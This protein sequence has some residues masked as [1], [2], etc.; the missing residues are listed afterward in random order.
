MNTIIA[1]TFIGILTYAF[2]EEPSDKTECKHEPMANF[3]PTKYLQITRAFV[4][5]SREG[6]GAIICRLYKTEQS[7]DKTGK[8]NT[9]IYEYY[10]KRRDIYYSEVHCNTTVKII[11]SGEFVSSCKKIMVTAR[12][13]DTTKIPKPRIMKVYTSVIDTDYDKYI[14]LYK[15]IKTK[16]GIKDN[17]QVL[18]TD[19]NAGDEPIKQALEKNGMEL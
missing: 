14:I 16:S 4:T 3:N 10:Q 9:N 11:K 15:C 12:R 7:G 18:Q 6:T 13:T 5:H 2:A 19:I 17:I 1:L 8:I